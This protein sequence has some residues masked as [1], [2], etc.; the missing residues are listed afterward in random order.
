M[1]GRSSNHRLI[2]LARKASHFTWVLAAYITGNSCTTIS[3]SEA[4]SDK[5]DATSVKEDGQVP[6]ESFNTSGANNPSHQPGASTTNQDTDTAKEVTSS[7][8]ETGEKSKTSSGKEPD[9]SQPNNE[10]G[11]DCQ[12][13]ESR[14]CSELDDGS[15]ITFPGGT[16]QGSCKYGKQICSDGKWTSCSGTIGPKAK[17]SCEAGNDDNCN[18]VTTDHCK[19]SAGKSESC[20]SDVG[21]CQKGQRTCKADG[22]WGECLGQTKPSKEICGG[23]NDEDC[24][25]ATDLDDSECDCLVGTGHTTCTLIG[26]GDCELGKRQCNGGKW[27]KCTPRFPIMI[28]ERCGARSDS[29]GQARGDEN[30]NGDVDELWPGKPIGCT[31]Y[32]LDEDRDG[33]GAMGSSANS[34]SSGGAT[35]GCFCSKPPGTGWTRATNSSVFNSDC[36]DCDRNVFPGQTRFFDSESQC[37]TQVGWIGQAFDY[38]CDRTSKKEFEEMI[39]CEERDD[40]CVQVRG[41]WSNEGGA[42]ECGQNGLKGYCKTYGG[43]TG[44]SLVDPVV[45]RCN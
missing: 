2:S 9:T 8:E 31:V 14:T 18:G 20:G 15:T 32:I 28:S 44:A 34:A 16:P 42:P 21:V 3:D 33:Y 45:Q 13:G 25:G 1:T 4:G 10:P 6:S 27:T 22:E 19:C 7:N 39:V 12:P 24:D 35:H 29:L 43:C 5:D 38:N 36:G 41:Y 30:C 37:L 40:E 26:L 17:D 23:G 11:P